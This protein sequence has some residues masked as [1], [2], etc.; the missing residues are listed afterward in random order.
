M[1]YLF[2][3]AVGLVGGYLIGKRSKVSGMLDSVGKM[4]KDG[5]L[6]RINNLKLRQGDEKADGVE[7]LIETYASGPGGPRGPQGLPVG[8]S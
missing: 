2:W 6:H 4:A 1:P 3:L 8:E 7:L 5:A